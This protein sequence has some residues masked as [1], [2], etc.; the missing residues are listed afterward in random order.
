VKRTAQP[1]LSA[2]AAHIIN[3]LPDPAFL[4]DDRGVIHDAN[5]AAYSRLGRARG[6][7]SG[8]RLLD[9]MRPAS[10]DEVETRLRAAAGGAQRFEADCEGP[11][12]ST[13]RVELSLC[14]VASA[15]AP[16]VLAVA[17]DMTERARVEEALRERTRMLRDIL[18]HNPG[19]VAV[20]D[21]RMRYLFVSDRWKE[22]YGVT[23]DVVGR[24]HY[25]VFP[26]LP[27]ALRAVDQRVLAGSYESA[28]DERYVREDGSIV[29]F[30]WSS[31][32]WF[33]E[34]GAIGGIVFY[35]E[36]IN[37]QRRIEDSLRRSEQELLDRNAFIERVIQ[38][39]PVGLVVHDSE[40]GR[41]ISMNREFERICGFPREELHTADF[42]LDA[43]IPDT[44]EGRRMA[45]LIRADLLRRPAGRL[46]WF[47]VPIAARADGVRRVNVGSLH[48]PDQHLFISTVTDVTE[49]IRDAEERARLE[50]QLAQ[51][52]KLESI[53]RLAGGIA[54][55]FNNMLQAI[56][57]YVDV[58]VKC[59]AMGRQPDRPLSEI[60]AAAHR[61][62][63]LTRQLLGFARRQPI[64]P[65]VTD[66]NAA[67]GGMLHLLRR[68]IGED[69]DLSWRPAEELPTVRIDPSQVDQ[70]LTNLCVNGR[71]AIGG[72]GRLVIGTDVVTVAGPRAAEHP[73]AAPG[74]YVRLSV[75]DTGSGMEPEVLQHIFEP[76]FT[77]KGIGRGTGLGLATV[78]GIVRQNHGF[79]D[80]ES[81]PGSGTTF[82]VCLPAWEGEEPAPPPPVPR[83][84]ARG[85]ETILLV[86]D[87][88]VLRTLTGELLT[89]LGYRVLVAGTPREAIQAADGFT[90]EIHLLLTDVVM[91]EMNG[92]A[93][94]NELGARRPGMRL[95]F[96]SGYPE[97]VVAHQGVI[98][99]GLHFIQKPFTEND[100]AAVVRAVLQEQPDDWMN[101]S[102]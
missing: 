74:R 77:T 44:A 40:T 92:P 62:A 96:M 61:A 18:E 3:A 100:L 14:G 41:I 59:T 11:G 19:G 23:E 102:R 45:A 12:G 80:V 91:P 60:R 27:P 1:S 89:G 57:G 81:A 78:Y 53:G 8:T 33:D 70:V 30:R 43:V 58:A 72:V 50:A 28:D 101:V 94:A 7:L 32:P 38:N 15:G 21:R 88:E 39:L 69:I 73:E 87:E 90:E 79:I 66:L 54:H 29:H 24:C 4:T 83:R 17:R 49:R 64:T 76:F 97:E 86:E 6:E 35:S 9:C 99:A 5:D 63:E 55:D 71:D 98:G 48:M 95:L 85:T 22:E 10:R 2:A 42:L 52:Q 20:L 37:D 13:I 34:A 93:L 56:L 84:M 82:A 25:D 68:L 26:D 65:R 51:A 67:V 47:D 31:R 36:F 16:L 46:A 75:S